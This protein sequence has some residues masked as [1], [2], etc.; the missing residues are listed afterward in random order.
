MNRK[1]KRLVLPIGAAAIIGTS[2]FAF[3]ANNTVP[4]THAGQGHGKISGYTIKASQ[5]HYS[6]ENNIGSGSPNNEY[7][8]SVSFTLDHD[9]LTKNVSALIYNSGNDYSKYGNC[10]SN[11]VSG[12]P[13][14]TCAHSGN[15]VSLHGSSKLLVNAAQ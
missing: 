10:S 8:K 6:L 9:A 13:T 2:G 15:E 12:T 5:V 11:G 7:I 3:M 4:E 14:F 1:M